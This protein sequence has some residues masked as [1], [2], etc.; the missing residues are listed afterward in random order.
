MGTILFHFSPNVGTMLVYQH[1]K[2]NHL[3][4]MHSAS[5]LELTVLWQVTIF[6][7]IFIFFFKSY[8]WERKKRNSL[9][10]WALSIFS[11]SNLSYF[12]NG[13]ISFELLSSYNKANSSSLIMFSTQD[14]SKLFLDHLRHQSVAM[15][16]SWKVHFLVYFF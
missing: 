6:S 3:S 9:L 8:V 13:Y 1:G 16:N 12:Q 15:L 7:G 4:K 2:A 11:K 14:K 10:H 5:T